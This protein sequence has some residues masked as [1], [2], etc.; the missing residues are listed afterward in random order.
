MTSAIRA[1]GLGERV[2]DCGGEGEIDKGGGAGGLQRSGSRCAARAFGRIRGERPPICEARRGVVRASRFVFAEVVAGSAFLTE[3]NISAIFSC[4]GN[5]SPKVA[6]PADIPVCYVV[7][8]NENLRDAQ[9]VDA[10]DFVESY[11][12]QGRNVVR[13]V[14]SS[15]R[16]PAS[17]ACALLSAPFPRCQRCASVDVGTLHVWQQ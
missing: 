9:L 11:A 16:R 10:C 12:L 1:V 17:C 15:S 7:V 8:N 6:Y 4:C 13:A 5:A 2:G 14:A 3:N